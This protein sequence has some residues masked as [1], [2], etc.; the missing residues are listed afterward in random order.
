MARESAGLLMYRFC[1]GQLQ[2]LLAHPGG[3]Y[4]QRKDE[5]AWTIPKGEPDSGEDLFV[6][7]RREFA[8]E[9]GLKP[10]GTFL[11]LKSVRQK[12]GKVV[13][14]WAIEG[15]CDPTILQS[16]SFTM[17]WPPKSS[18]YQSFPEVDRIEFFD[19]ATAKQKI[20][21]G[22]EQFLEELA[23]LVGKK[24]ASSTTI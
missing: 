16:N 21:A 18:L 5:F 17:E 7:A 19:M 11:P 12:G 24:S 4:F 20:K 13:H 10:S 23:A 14:A 15:D 6:A 2:V 22:Q 1:D 9:T 8:E 3:P